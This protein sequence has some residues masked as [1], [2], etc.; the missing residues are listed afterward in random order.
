M[1]KLRAESFAISLDGYGARS[2]SKPGELD[3]LT[4]RP[5][6]GSHSSVSCGN[7]SPRSGSPGGRPPVRSS[8]SARRT[9]RRSLAG[10]RRHCGPR[11]PLMKKYDGKQVN[12]PRKLAR[13]LLTLANSE[14]PPLRCTAGADAVNWFEQPLASKRAE[15][16]RW[17]ALSVSLCQARITQGGARGLAGALARRSPGDPRADALRAPKPMSSAS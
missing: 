9:S 13:V 1:T 2:E 15:L 6:K 16:G 14:D 7:H 3:G 10:L 4:A 11:P 17:H 12:D 8:P 5:H